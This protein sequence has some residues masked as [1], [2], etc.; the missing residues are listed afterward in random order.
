MD[1]ILKILSTR[2]SKELKDRSMWEMYL[3]SDI[4]E[5]KTMAQGNINP[6]TF[7]CE[8]LRKYI[9]LL[10]LLKTNSGFTEIEFQ[11]DNKIQQSIKISK[12]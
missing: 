1:Y 11:V 9:E 6:C 12:L 3:E 2:L 5:L 8:E 7:R 10:T 4:Q